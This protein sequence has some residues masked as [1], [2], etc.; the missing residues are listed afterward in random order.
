MSYSYHHTSGAKTKEFVYELIG[1]EGVIRYD[2]SAKS[3][4]TDRA[5]GCTD[6]ELHDEKSFDGLYAEWARALEAGHSDLL[7]SAEAGMRVVEITR[8]ATD[9]VIR[10]RRAESH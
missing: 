3:F 4:R 2:R 5:S 6:F 1:T 9:Q 7:T 10:S 8:N